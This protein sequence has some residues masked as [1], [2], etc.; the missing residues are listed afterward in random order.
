MKRITMLVALV[1]LAGTAFGQTGNSK[2]AL[3]PAGQSTVIEKVRD[4]ALSYTKQL[5]NPA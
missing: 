3:T 4:H 5:P 2:R 1:C